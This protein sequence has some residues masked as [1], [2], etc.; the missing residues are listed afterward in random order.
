[1]AMPDESNALRPAAGRGRSF[2]GVRRMEPQDDGVHLFDDKDAEVGIVGYGEQVYINGR[3]MSFKAS[4][5]EDGPAS[6]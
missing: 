2:L 5:P 6:R 1:M 4:Q 3:V